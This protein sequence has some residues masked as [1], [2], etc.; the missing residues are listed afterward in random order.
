MVDGIGKHLSQLT[1]LSVGSQTMARAD[2]V[3]VFQAR[4]DTG[5]AAQAAKAARTTT[6]LEDRDERLKTA[7]LVRSFRR[8]VLGMFE[9]SPDILA[10]FRLK[11]PKAGKRTVE[12]MT[13]AVAK[14][15]ATRKARNTMGSKQRLSI[16][17]T[18]TEAPLPSPQP[19]PPVNAG[20]APEPAVPIAMPKP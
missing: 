3:K 18:V 12:T 6:A 13:A 14:S 1:S 4:V 20:Q 7:A 11:A 5:K 8:I 15:K 19:S 10:E 9:K 16:T 17:G 2:I